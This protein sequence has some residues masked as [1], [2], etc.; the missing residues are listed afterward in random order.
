MASPTNG[1]LASYHIE[2]NKY[3]VLF[4]D[5]HVSAM[6]SPKWFNPRNPL[7]MTSS[8]AGLKNQSRFWISMDNAR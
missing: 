8:A 6:S 7:D 5:G 4:G 2:L 3:P 1:L